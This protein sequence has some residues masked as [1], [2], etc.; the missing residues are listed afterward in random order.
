MEQWSTHNSADFFQTFTLH[1]PGKILKLRMNV[2]MNYFQFCDRRS[3][4]APTCRA[5]S[6]DG[7][8][9]CS[10]NARGS[11]DGYC[12]YTHWMEAAQQGNGGS[13]YDEESTARVASLRLAGTVQEEAQVYTEDF[14]YQCFLELCGAQ[15]YTEDSLYQCFRRLCGRRRRRKQRNVH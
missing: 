5:R 7:L 1:L 8:L 11:Y 9:V 14:L 13:I 10:R 3:T 6:A 15:D 2:A 4:T 12:G